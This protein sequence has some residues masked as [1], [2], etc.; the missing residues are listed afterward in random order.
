MIMINAESILLRGVERDE[1]HVQPPTRALTLPPSVAPHSPK[2]SFST[3]NPGKTR[4]I[5]DQNP[6][7]TRGK[8]GG[9]PGNPGEIPGKSRGNPG[10]FPGSRLYRPG[11][12]RNS[13]L[14]LFGEQVPAFFRV[15]LAFPFG[16]DE[17]RDGV[18]DEV[19]DGAGFGHESIDAK[20]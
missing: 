15:E 9:N 6:G 16:D 18:A 5:N 10:K 20:N 3:V 11:F 12:D 4:E 19:G 8:P 14:G 17:H 1:N 13:R 7:E 2:K